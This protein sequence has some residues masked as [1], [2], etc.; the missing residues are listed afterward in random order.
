MD[1]QEIM[2]KDQK[3]YRNTLESV[4]QCALPMVRNILGIQRKRVSDFS[5]A[6]PS[7]HWGI[8]IRQL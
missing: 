5:Q 2:Q 7:A 1:L 3:Y 8:N 6:L 4:F